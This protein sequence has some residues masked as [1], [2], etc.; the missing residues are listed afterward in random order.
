[1]NIDIA[2]TKSYLTALSQVPKS[3]Q[4]KA[5]NLFEKFKLNPTAA[6]INYESIINMKDD[7]VRI[8]RVD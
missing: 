8:I 2:I 7:K 1:M 3:I 6:S 5:N 4:K